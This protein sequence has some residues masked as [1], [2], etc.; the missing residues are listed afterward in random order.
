MKPNFMWLQIFVVGILGPCL[1]NAS[2]SDH[3]FKI[4]ISTTYDH[5]R[6]SDPT[7][8]EFDAW[9][10]IDET[11]VSGTVQAPSGTSYPLT[12]VEEDGERWLGYYF[13][14]YDVN[15]LEDYNDGTYSFTVEYYDNSSDSTSVDYLLENGEPI[16]PVTQVPAFVYPA[17]EETDVPL[18]LSFQF[19]PALDP[20]LEISL[21]W[22]P[23]YSIPSPFLAAEAEKLHYNVSS[24]G[25]VTLSPS[26]Y[27]DV[28]LVLNRVVR[29]VNTDGI[30]AVLDKDAECDVYFTTASSGAHAFRVVADSNFDG[31]VN[32]LDLAVLASKWLDRPDEK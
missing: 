21:S 9:I 27:Y 31:Q 7:N 18:V 1:V 2:V 32:L 5:D 29:T 11:V 4:E 30:P 22:E 13:I 15:D 25:P 19:E 28:E 17:Q 10:Q 12:L 20:N 14:S 24:Y 3:V 16:P 23:E 26:I 8:Y 6:P